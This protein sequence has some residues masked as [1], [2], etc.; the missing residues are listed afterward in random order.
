MIVEHI[1]FDLYQKKI[2]EK[3]VIVPPLKM[4]EMLENEACFMYLVSGEQEIN[5][6]TEHWRLNAKEAV[7]MKCGAH[8]AEWLK[9][10]KTDQC[11][12]IAIHLYPDVLKKIYEKELPAFIVGTA[13]SKTEI[14]SKII[15]DELIYNYI[16]SMQ[17]YFNNPTLVSDELLVL[18]LKELILLLTKTENASSIQHLFTRLFTPRE[19]SFKE[20]IE[21]H[22]LSNLTINDL[23]KLTNMSVS[24]FKRVFKS[25]FNDSPAH[26]FL[27]KKVE[28][29]AE[30]LAISDQRISDIAFDCG[31]NDQSHFSKSFQKKFGI[32]PSQY[33]LNQK[34]KILD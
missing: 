13:S 21:A 8:F 25:I 9:T 1:K 18:K 29:S 27:N 3:M 22:T 31:F 32:S 30:L 20:I 4:H 15:N 17:F 19:F 5:S 11:E 7:L 16:A 23:A 6:T 10:S 14:T 24:S 28:H 2:F 12:A 33:R 34:N 26:Y